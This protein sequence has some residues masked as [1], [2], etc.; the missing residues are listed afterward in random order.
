MNNFCGR[1]ENRMRR[2]V[3]AE[4]TH[5]CPI[6]R[7]FNVTAVQILNLLLSLFF[8]CMYVRSC[9]GVFTTSPDVAHAAPTYGSRYFSRQGSDN[10]ETSM[11]MCI[12]ERLL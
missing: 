1:E 11:V 10:S 3:E 12:H 2:Q 6:H 9:G 7:R 8:F 4:N 5:S